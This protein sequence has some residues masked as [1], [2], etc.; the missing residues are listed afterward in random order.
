[1]PLYKSITDHPATKV[2]IWKIE[3]SEE[4]LQKGIQLTSHCQ[5]RLDSM[6]SEI[7][8]RGFL[9]VRQLLR[10]AGYTPSDLYYDTE[11]RPHLRD[12]KKISITHSFIFSAII[13]SDSI[14]GIDIEKQREKIKNIAHKFV[15]Y[16][17]SYLRNG[18]MV[19]MLTVIW[20]A[21]E[22]LYKAYA[23]NGV[24]F[25][26]NIKVIPFNLEEP[27]LIAWIQYEGDLQKYALN[28]LEFEGFSCAY[29]LKL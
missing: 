12:G 26:N 10:E 27:A 18:E 13:V 16:E 4:A 7:H 17:M 6:K 24:S 20:C 19:R 28:F 22:S 3:E 11:G 5:N 8:R 21:K 29:A 2:L 14:I 25:K 9:S 15:D 1:M 23:T